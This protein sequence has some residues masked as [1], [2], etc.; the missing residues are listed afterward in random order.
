[1]KLESDDYTAD[2]VVPAG[3]GLHSVAPAV[4]ENSFGGQFAQEPL[5]LKVPAGQDEH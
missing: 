1:V 4:A 3:Q 2:E 5:E